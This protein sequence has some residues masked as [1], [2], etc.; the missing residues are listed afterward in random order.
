MVQRRAAI[1]VFSCLVILAG[2][3]QAGII[4]DNGLPDLVQGGFSDF[5]HGQQMA[6]DFN[7]ETAQ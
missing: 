4:Y 2:S 7:F 1:I 3:A 6:D 5:D